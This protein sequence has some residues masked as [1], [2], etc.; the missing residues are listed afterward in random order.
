MFFLF[1]FIICFSLKYSHHQKFFLFIYSFTF[2]FSSSSSFN[3][4]SKNFLCTRPKTCT[5]IFITSLIHFL[6][7]LKISIRTH[8]QTQKWYFVCTGFVLKYVYYTHKHN[9]F[10]S[11][12]LLL[13]T[14]T[15]QL[16]NMRKKKE[17]HFTNK[18]NR[19]C[20][21]VC[22]CVF[23]RVTMGG[24]YSLTRNILSFFFAWICAQAV[25]TGIFTIFYPLLSVTKESLYVRVHLF[26][27]NNSISVSF[28]HFLNE[29]NS[30]Q[31]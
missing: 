19:K 30:H 4:Y 17:V 10:I 28:L 13:Y 3:I 18:V 29:M 11:E 24:I 27:F 7:M 12:I 20:V 6:F 23:V 2:R 5:Y 21:C 15:Q 22:L 9:K 26:I 16:S 14:T 31:L 8:T 25:K 1:L